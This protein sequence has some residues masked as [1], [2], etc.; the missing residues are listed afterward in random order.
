MNGEFANKVA[1]VTGAASGIG[2]VSA[3]YYAREGAQV[4][5][6]DVDEAGG[7]E[8]VQL[9]QEAGGEALLSRPTSRN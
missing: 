9:I 7:E 2:R 1:L 5:V 8:T 4:V 6:S 3:Q